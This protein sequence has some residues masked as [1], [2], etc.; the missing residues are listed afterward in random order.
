M[1]P[2]CFHM[3][4]VLLRREHM[5]TKD[6]TLK[7]PIIFK[8]FFCQYPL[9]NYPVYWDGL[10]FVVLLKFLQTWPQC[11]MLESY[12]RSIGIVGSYCKWGQFFAISSW[13]IRKSL[14]LSEDAYVPQILLK[15]QYIYIRT[16][17]SYFLLSALL[18]WYILKLWAVLAEQPALYTW[19]LKKKVAKSLLSEYIYCA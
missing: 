3:I 2:F 16:G 7:F 10:H 18:N 5:W 17:S 19:F 14:G 11:T 1:E 15:P 4:C 6:A 13:W 8:R 9:M 12:R